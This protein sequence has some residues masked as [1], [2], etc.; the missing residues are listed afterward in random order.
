MRGTRIRNPI[1]HGE[2][3]A[4]DDP[5]PIDGYGNAEDVIEAGNGAHQARA[6][7][8]GRGAGE[9]EDIGTPGIHGTGQIDQLR[10]HGDE[11]ASDRDGDAELVRTC[12]YWI[13]QRHARHR[14]STAAQ[15]EDVSSAGTDAGSVV[16]VG[17]DHHP[18]PVD[19]HRHAEGIIG[20]RA[21]V[22]QSDDRHSRRVA[23]QI[24]DIR[25][26][27]V[28]R[29]RRISK[30]CPDD[31]QIAR[32]RDGSS[33]SAASFRIRIRRRDERRHRHG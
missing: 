15:V 16:A 30:E 12:R 29:S 32:D 9:I 10:S 19:R 18:I 33:E 31:H 5:I 2:R 1:D 23:G 14:G 21:W 20:V 8:G 26:T 7:N 24:I 3:F 22:F 27:R 11:I 17:T 25:G 13:R 6:R 4:H 28:R